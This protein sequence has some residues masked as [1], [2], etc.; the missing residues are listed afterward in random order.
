[1]TTLWPTASFARGT[2]PPTVAVVLA[3]GWS[4]RMGAFKPLLP[5]GP[6][7]VI[8]HVVATLRE[9]GIDRIRVVTGHNADDLAPVLSRLDVTA[10]HNPDFDRGMYSSIRAGIA[11]LPPDIAG[12]LLLPVDIPLVRASTIAALIGAAIETGAA[13]VHPTFSDGRGHPPFL[14]R[15]LVRDIVAG[16]GDGGLRRLIAAHVQDAVDVAVIDRGILLDMDTPADYAQLVRML[17]ARAVPDPVEC[18]AMLAAAMTPEPVRRHARAVAGLAVT[19][20][21]RLQAAG[22]PVDLDLVAAGALLHDI[23]K[24]HPRH[25]DLGAELLRGLGFGSVAEVVACHMDLALADQPPVIDARAI[26]FLADKLIS[27]QRRVSLD[28]RFAAGLRRYAADAAALAGVVRRKAEAEAVLHAV[29]ALI[30]L[31][32]A[33][34]AMDADAPRHAGELAGA[35]AKRPDLRWTP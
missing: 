2:R 19:I 11:D 35:D 8:E 33:T 31:P 20:A 25:A 23:A 16:D 26:V 10:V 27:D 3:A 28:Q 15:R 9:G 7:T 14:A 17:P 5:F 21:R 6:R 24:G 4:S 1:M 29:E 13:V 30:D 34:D 32:E 22:Q 12:A 18:E